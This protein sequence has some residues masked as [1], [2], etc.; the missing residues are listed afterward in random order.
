M[1]RPFTLQEALP[2]SPQTSISP[3]VAGTSANLRLF[4]PRSPTHGADEV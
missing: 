1:A 4:V 2:Y 3:F